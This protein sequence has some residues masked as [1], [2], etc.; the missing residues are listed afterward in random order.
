[1]LAS[2]GAVVILHTPSPFFIMG[3]DVPTG[4][5]S[6]YSDTCAAFEARMRNVTVRSLCT[7]GDTSPSGGGVCPHAHDI[8][9]IVIAKYFMMSTSQILIVLDQPVVPDGTEDVE[10]ER[11]FESH[12]T[13][14]NKRRD[15][16]HLA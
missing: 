6:P 1:M 14:R 16:Q 7:S 5:Q 11:V 8:A 12:G 10:I 9:A 3:A 2:S 15:A 13:M 4:I